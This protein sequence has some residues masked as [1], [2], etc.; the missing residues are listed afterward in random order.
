MDGE[1]F[2][3]LTSMR[4]NHISELARSVVG[5]E[6]IRRARGAI[7]P[8]YRATLYN[9]VQPVQNR[10]RFRRRLSD[11]PQYDLDDRNVLFVAVDCLRNDHLS[12]AGYD[13]ETTP[14]L[15]SVGNYYPNCASAASWT[16]SSVPSI[17][18]GMYP[19]NHGAVFESKFRNEGMDTPPT[20]VREDVYTLP[21]V[22]AKEGY[23]TYLS[24]AIA[25]AELPVRG[26]FKNA[27]IYHD[28]HYNEPAEDM[29]DHLLEWWDSA[30][31]P[32]FGYVHLGDLHT[33]LRRPEMKPF[34]EI[35]NIPDVEHWDFTHTTE[36]E[37]KFKA[38]RQ[39]K[40][41]LYDSNLRY[42][43]D[44]IR[45]LFGA[46]S[47]RDELD[48]TLIVVVGDHGE[49]F[50]ER[51]ELERNHF[52]D[53]RGIYG[54][55]HGHA[56][57]PEVLFVPLIIVGGSDRQTTEWTSTTDI[58]PTTLAELSASNKLLSSLD[59]V[60]LQDP[61]PDRGVLAE[62]IAYG[63]DQQAVVRDGHLLIHSPHENET[64][65][66]DIATDKLV[67]DPE[68]ASKLKADLADEKHVGT[69]AGLDSKTEERLTDLGYI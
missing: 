19:H 10:V 33:H 20:R 15:D 68:L 6:R 58:V 26:R 23:D 35:P 8:I 21:E 53:P 12:R 1:E 4:T 56:L 46:L 44:Q 29:V 59:G 11:V 49:E 50:W 27:N 17:L 66:L 28:S 62:E 30:D 40:L 41:K 42:V 55:G 63:Y 52:K 25:T 5:N 51:V 67:D 24:T 43:D 69:A 22:L 54:T 2:K 36:P 16:Y 3:R 31:G 65:V 47:V 38:Y 18:T 13:R 60:P 39:A 64:V 48:D 34:G 14:F 61:V 57:I 45:R 9:L 32:R 37:D 7:G